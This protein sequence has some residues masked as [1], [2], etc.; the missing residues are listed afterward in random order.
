MHDGAPAFT[1]AYDQ[2]DVMSNYDAGKWKMRITYNTLCDGEPDTYI[3]YAKFR[4]EQGHP[5]RQLYS[6][7]R[8]DRRTRI[9]WMGHLCS[10]PIKDVKQR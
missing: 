7:I 8:W 1:L 9:I 5:G 10:R 2:N 4:Y 3:N 6:R